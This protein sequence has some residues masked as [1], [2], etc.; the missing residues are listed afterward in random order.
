MKLPLSVVI[1]TYNEEDNIAA[2]LRQLTWVDEI[3]VV[4]SFSTDQTARIAK[5]FP[6]CF[7]QRI[8]QSPAD[9]KNWAIQQTKHQWVLILDADERLT[10][11]LEK[12]IKEIIQ[13]EISEYVGYTIYRQNYF[14]GKAIKYCGL[15]RDR[16]IRLIQK[17]WCVY[18]DNQVH[19]KIESTGKIGTLNHK[20]EHYTY[21]NL[22]HFLA[23]NE[24]YGIWSGQDYF[25]SVPNVT[26]FHLWIKPLWRFLNQ[27]IFKKGFLD[28]QAGFIFCV[29]MAWGVF[30]RY[31]TIK[32][33]RQ[34]ASKK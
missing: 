15:Q 4:D 12:E 26:L 22:Q 3:I 5:A 19:E 10:A 7:L 24:R 32:E 8:Y 28:G 23:K 17:D 21:K 31:V 13:Q 6:I 34:N 14:M 20:L 30:L 11:E 9:Q 2:L 27:Y 18:N 16:V 33:M 25:D 1:P 29:I